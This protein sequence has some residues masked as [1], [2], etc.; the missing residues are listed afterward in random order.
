MRTKSAATAQ[1]CC[2]STVALLISFLLHQTMKLCTFF[3]LFSLS[4]Y[5]YILTVSRHIKPIKFIFS[6][7]QNKNKNFHTIADVP[8][9]IFCLF[10]SSWPTNC[11]L[12]LS[13]TLVVCRWIFFHSTSLFVFQIT[14]NKPLA[15]KTYSFHCINSFQNRFFF[16]FFNEVLIYKRRNIQIFA[17]ANICHFLC[18]LLWALFVSLLRLKKKNKFHIV[19]H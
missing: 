7:V 19:M 16:K 8:I 15:R 1:N 6:M 13:S 12:V 14:I 11:D 4:L 9:R 2:F 3:L 17:S 10:R 5:I 18:S